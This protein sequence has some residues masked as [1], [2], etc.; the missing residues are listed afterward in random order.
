M[1]NDFVDRDKIDATKMTYGAIQGMLSTLGDEN[2]TVFF[3]PEEAKQQAESME[4]RSKVSV[5]TSSR[6]RATSTS[7]PHPRLAGRGRGHSGRAT[8][9]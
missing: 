1:D 3:S 4:G 2:H 5:H 6:R 7:S 8:R 9:A